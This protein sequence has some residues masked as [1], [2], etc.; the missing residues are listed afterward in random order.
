MTW[1]DEPTARWIVAAIVLLFFMH[2][3]GQGSRGRR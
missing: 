2:V 1:P 3:M